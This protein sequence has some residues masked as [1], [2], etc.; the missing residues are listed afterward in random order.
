MGNPKKNCCK[1]KLCNPTLNLCTIHLCTKTN[2]KAHK[3]NIQGSSR[4]EQ[5]FQHM[6]KPTHL[7]FK[8]M[9]VYVFFPLFF[10][11]FFFYFL[12]LGYWTIY[13][14]RSTASPI[15]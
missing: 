8:V 6:N 3:D 9:G 7:D 12:L 1:E 13:V 5:N 11:F 2:E 4:P 14:S 10:S 15:M